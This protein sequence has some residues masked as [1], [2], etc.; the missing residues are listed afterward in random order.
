MMELKE[1]DGFL[2]GFVAF[3]GAVW[4]DWR[5]RGSGIW[6]GGD[7]ARAAGSGND[8]PRAA[9]G[10]AGTDAAAGRGPGPVLGAGLFRRRAWRGTA[11]GRRS[12]RWCG[13]A[14][15]SSWTWPVTE[16]IIVIQPRMTGGFWLRRARSTRPHP[17]GVPRGQTPSDGLV[18]RHAAAGQDRL[19][20]PMP[21]RRPRRS[22]ARTGRMPWRSAATSWRNGS[23]EPPAGSSR[24]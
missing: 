8:G 9:A 12:A 21:M 20:S 2:V 14:S 10:A 17:P 7:D 19:V 15:G 22:R 24:P 13:E 18:L 3:V 6:K 1:F 5:D 4:Y 23:R 11:G 16:G